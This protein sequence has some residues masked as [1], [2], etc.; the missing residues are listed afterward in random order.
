MPDRCHIRTSKRERF[1]DRCAH[2]PM[3]MLPYQTQHLDHL[4]GAAR[5]T[6]SINQL[7]EQPI[8]TLGPQPTRPPCGQRFRADERTRFAFQH[9]QIMFEIEH[10]LAAFVA[11]LVASD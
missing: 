6:M 9:V 3:P 4:A 11:A 8:V 10:L 1:F 2:P 7:C 5:F